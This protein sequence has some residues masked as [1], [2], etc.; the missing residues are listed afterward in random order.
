MEK[1]K[2]CCGE[3]HKERGEREKR[4]LTNRINRIEGQVRAIG[5]MIEENAYC[6]D[7]LIQISAAESALAAL[8]RVMLTEHINTCVLEDIKAGK[9]EA[10]E[11]LASLIEKLRK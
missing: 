11:E 8:S 4:L 6:P 10:S 9:S 2:N 1:C 7:I 3:R 5:K